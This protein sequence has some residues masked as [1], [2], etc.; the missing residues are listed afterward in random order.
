MQL[1]ET[2]LEKHGWMFSP[3]LRLRVREHECGSGKWDVEMD[4]YTNMHS[5]DDPRWEF[6]SEVFD[7]A[8]TVSDLVKEHP[9]LQVRDW[10]DGDTLKFF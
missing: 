6:D 8:D 7:A 1:N 5:A 10:V 4:S 9:E 3:S 2:N